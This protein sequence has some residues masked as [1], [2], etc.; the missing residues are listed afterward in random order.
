MDSQ[1]GRNGLTFWVVVGLK[2]ERRENRGPGGLAETLGVG[3]GAEILTPSSEATG[4]HPRMRR[5]TAREGNASA[6]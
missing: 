2:G 6:R 1:V 3:R 4:H 5:W